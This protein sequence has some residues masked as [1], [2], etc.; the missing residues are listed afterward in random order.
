MLLGSPGGSA[1]TDAQVRASAIWMGL[2][3]NAPGFGNGNSTAGYNS[4]GNV[5]ALKTDT[6]LYLQNMPKSALTSITGIDD[7]NGAAAPGGGYCWVVGANGSVYGAY[8][9]IG[10]AVAVV[11]QL[12]NAAGT[13]ADPGGQGH[14]WFAG[15]AGA[16]P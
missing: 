5:S 9:V 7:A 13:I 8:M 4:R 2:L 12:G 14:V 11:D 6:G 15:F 3:V 16:Y 1:I 10:T